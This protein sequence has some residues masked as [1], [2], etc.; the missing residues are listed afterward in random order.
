MRGSPWLLPLVVLHTAFTGII[1]NTLG[2]LM[3]KQSE[4]EWVG[5]GRLKIG[6]YEI[7]GAKHNPVI[8]AMWELSLQA[9]KQ[10]T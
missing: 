5:I 4:L 2:L 6:T 7:K 8:V 9:T 3:T 10:K 1:T